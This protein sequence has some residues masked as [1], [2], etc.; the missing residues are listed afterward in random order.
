MNEDAK[1]ASSEPKE[2][3]HDRKSPT[4]IPAV[5]RVGEGQQAARSRGRRAKQRARVGITADDAVEG[6][7]VRLGQRGGDRRKISKNKLRGTRA[8]TRPNVAARKFEVGGRGIGKRHAG[9]AGGG[10]FP[11]DYANAGADIEKLEIVERPAAEFGE[12]HARTGVRAASLVAAQI[13]IR[14]AGVEEA[15]SCAMT[16]AAGHA[17]HLSW[18]KAVELR[19]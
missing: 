9:Q 11:S 3:V 13:T 5:G 15:R 8:I 14:N 18:R 19:V 2:K 4:K 10:E 12:E 16:G 6:N 7:N 17:A 1:G